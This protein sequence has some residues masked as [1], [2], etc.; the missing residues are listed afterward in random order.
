M[1]TNKIQ[2]RGKVWKNNSSF[3]ITI[4]EAVVKSEKLTGGEYLNITLE[5]PVLPKEK[6]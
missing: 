2:F 4:P 3:L 6:R 5:I 1:E